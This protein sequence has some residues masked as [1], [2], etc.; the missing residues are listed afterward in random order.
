MNINEILVK[1]DIILKK[2]QS[3][4]LNELFKTRSY[5][6]IIGIGLNSKNMILFFRDAKSRFISKDFVKLDEMSQIIINKSGRVI[7]EKLFFYNS[8]IC[9]KTLALL[10]ENGWKCFFV[11]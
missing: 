7:R 9:S 2:S 8:K 11:M 1:N 3:V 10:R 6:C 5:E 4:N